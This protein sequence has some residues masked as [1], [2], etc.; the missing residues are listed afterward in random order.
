MIKVQFDIY[1]LNS[2]C[3]TDIVNNPFLAEIL[4]L[5]F[6]NGPGKIKPAVGL[7]M[8]ES[9]PHYLESCFFILCAP[10]SMIR[11][12]SILV[13]ALTLST[14]G[15]LVAILA[16]MVIKHTLAVSTSDLIGWSLSLAS[17][18]FGAFFYLFVATLEESVTAP[19]LLLWIYSVNVIVSAPITFVM[20]DWYA[21][22]SQSEAALGLCRQ[23]E[24]LTKLCICST[25]SSKCVVLATIRDWF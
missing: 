7:E 3:S 8:F 2:G 22:G 19:I 6:A 15:V 14:I 24:T 10:L 18:I 20:D 1:T 12:L 5:L 13:A 11:T 9:T 17:S 23:A 21:I 25:R 4:F 16:D